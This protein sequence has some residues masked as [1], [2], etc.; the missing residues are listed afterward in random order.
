MPRIERLRQNTPQWLRWRRGGIGSSDAPAIMGE[1]AFSSARMLW[2]VKTGRSAERPDSPAMRRGRGLEG[3]A[4]LAYEAA[5]GVLT[6][7][8]C[9]A[10]DDREWM[11]ASLDGLSLD[12]AIALEIKCPLNGKDHE[13]AQRGEAPRH[14][15]A[16][17]QHQLEVS[18]ASEAHYWSFDGER[19]VLVRVTP[20]REYIARLIAAE[21]L[22]WRRVCEDRWPEESRAEV[23]DLGADRAWELA[24]A[25]Y[26]TAKQSLELASMTERQARERLLKLAAGPR[27]FGFGVEVVRSSRRGAIDYA[28]IPELRSVDLEPYRKPPVEVVTVSLCG[29]TATDP[30]LREGD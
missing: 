20:D 10:H 11:R 13:T 17:L 19:G 14:Y 1:S 24:A 28:A 12:G 23:L 18:G 27:T 29:A 2:A 26:R 5:T 4:R 7:P 6:E 9:L 15:Y 21:R 3:A 16:Q 30:K 8:V 25:A 22:F